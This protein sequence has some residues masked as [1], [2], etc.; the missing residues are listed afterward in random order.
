MPKQVDTSMIKDCIGVKEGVDEDEIR[1]GG[2]LIQETL[3]AYGIRVE[4][5]TAEPRLSAVYYEVFPSKG[6]GFLELKSICMI[7]QFR[8]AQFTHEY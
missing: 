5:I 6:F 4:K 3:D 7:F 2:L 1:K 8:L